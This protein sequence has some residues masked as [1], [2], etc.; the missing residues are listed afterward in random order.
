M[1]RARTSNFRRARVKAV[2]L[3][4]CSTYVLCNIL[5][6]CTCMYRKEDDRARNARTKVNAY[7]RM[8]MKRQAG[9]RQSVLNHMLY[10]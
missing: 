9:S 3:H 8:Y 4:V 7:V 10:L 1:I 5:C 6:M 2:L